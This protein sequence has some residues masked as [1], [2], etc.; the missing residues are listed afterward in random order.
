MK[1]GRGDGEIR[2]RELRRENGEF[3]TSQIDKGIWSDFVGEE[4]KGYR[5]ITCLYVYHP[6]TDDLYRVEFSP[7]C[8]METRTW[9]LMP[10]KYAKLSKSKEVVSNDY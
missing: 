9:E 3:T 8:S 5:V 10:K 4:G 7:V 6:E 1:Y 2:I